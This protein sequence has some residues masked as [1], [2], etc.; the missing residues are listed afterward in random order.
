MKAIDRVKAAAGFSEYD[1]PPFDFFEEAGYL[2]VDGKYTP[3]RRLSMTFDEQVDARSEF[4]KK[5]KT[6]LIF[7]IP[8]FIPTKIPCKVTLFYEGT[9]LDSPSKL[10]SSISGMAWNA[11]PPKVKGEG[12]LSDEAA[13]LITKKILWDNG[14]ESE[15]VID[16]ATGTSDISQPA[17]LQAED[18]LS[19]LECLRGDL[20]KADFSYLSRI[21]KSVGDNIAL[22]G[23]V[24][25]PV[26]AIG[27]YLGVESLMYML[28]DKPGLLK[29]ICDE[30]CDICQETSTA[31]IENGMDLIRL[32]AATACLL[33][34][35]LFLEFCA[36]YQRRICDA[37][38]A[39]GGM[40]HL[41]MCGNVK[42]LLTPIL[43]SKADILETI[44]PPPLGNTTLLDAKKSIGSRICLRGNLNP[45]GALRDGTPEEALAE[46][47]KCLKEGMEGGGFIFSVADNLASGTPEK[48]IAAIAKYIISLS[49]S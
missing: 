22:S 26:S 6:D 7:D 12:L 4:Q 18:I 25:D 14:L 9:E 30:L 47:E 2:F 29:D 10:Y 43:E 40:T 5:F 17:F 37:V 46:A 27:W 1:R 19:K 3:S 34:P 11:M 32:G 48:N 20:A 15:E 23:T 31:M 38:R 33:S 39:S 49:K 24:I 8:V 28:F 44:T 41:H 13:G 16:L 35:D 21:R 42:N 45:A 36:P